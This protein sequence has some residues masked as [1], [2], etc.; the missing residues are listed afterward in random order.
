MVYLEY[1]PVEENQDKKHEFYPMETSKL[2][3][4]TDYELKLYIGADLNISH[5][6][7]HPTLWVSHIDPLYTDKFDNERSKKC[8][9][10]TF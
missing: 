4:K 2:N 10:D 8:C 3:H 6:W 9:I 1:T 7:I 5:S